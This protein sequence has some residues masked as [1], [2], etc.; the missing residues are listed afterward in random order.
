MNNVEF[1]TE[2]E[3]L[4]CRFSWI[5]RSGNILMIKKRSVSKTKL[6]VKRM[7]GRFSAFYIRRSRIL[8]GGGTNFSPDVIC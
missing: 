8:P 4:K 6:I 3:T 2:N 1:P 5:C 7:G